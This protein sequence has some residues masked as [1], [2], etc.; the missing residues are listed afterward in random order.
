MNLNEDPSGQTATTKSSG[1]EEENWRKQNAASGNREKAVIE[2]FESS[3][4]WRVEWPMNHARN[5]MTR[6]AG[7]NPN[8]ANTKI[9]AFDSRIQ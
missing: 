3:N 2:A 1:N 5:A 9:L 7:F 4:R 6:Y 8:L